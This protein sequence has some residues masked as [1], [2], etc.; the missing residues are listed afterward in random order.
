MTV[1]LR[2]CC[3]GN[4]QLQNF[5]TLNFTVRNG[6][7]PHFLTG[8][9][10]GAKGVQSIVAGFFLLVLEEADSV[11]SSWLTTGWVSVVL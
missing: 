2:G 7:W 1:C 5:W 8:E 3:R 10:Q 9:G 6:G 11:G 4:G